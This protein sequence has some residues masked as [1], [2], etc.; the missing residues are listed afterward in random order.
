MSLYSIHP[1][2]NIDSLLY[3]F[4]KDTKFIFFI[5]LKNLDL[6]VKNDLFKKLTI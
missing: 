5:Y 2:K 6:F 4:Y 1:K 3:I